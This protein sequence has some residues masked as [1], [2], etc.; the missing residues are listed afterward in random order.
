[1]IE[2]YF[3]LILNK[4]VCCD[5]SFSEPSLRETVLICCDPSL[6]PSL[7]ETVL[8]RGHNIHFKAA[9]WKII[10]KLSLLEY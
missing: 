10:P 1:M 5:P 7:R 6:E 3:F 8:M 2:R 4:H 9:I